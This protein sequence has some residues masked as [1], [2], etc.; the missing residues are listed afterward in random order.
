MTQEVHGVGRV[1]I[2]IKFGEHLAVDGFLFVP[3]MRV[4]LLSVSALGDAGYMTLFKSVHVF[5]YK[6]G[7]D[8][9]EP[10]LNGDHIYRL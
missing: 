8:L 9:V 3:S 1:K 2:H 5:I 10:Q 4:N 6:E 7:A